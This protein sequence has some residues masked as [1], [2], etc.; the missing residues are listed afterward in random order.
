[1]KGKKLA[2][3]LRKNHLYLTASLWEPCGMHHIEGAQCGLPL[4]YHEDGGGIVEFGRK[5]GIGFRH[6]VK[7]AILD[8]REKYPLLR[9]KV[10]KGMPSGDE[11]CR[12]YESILLQ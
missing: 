1:V 7:R 4:V 12:K 5:Y 2:N 10:L 9:E 11:M 3:L 6:D 8:A